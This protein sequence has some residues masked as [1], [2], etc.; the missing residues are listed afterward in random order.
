[1]TTYT[2][3]TKCGHR[4]IIN[5][6]G[7]EEPFFLVL[8]CESETVL[9]EGETKVRKPWALSNLGIPQAITLSEALRLTAHWLSFYEDEELRQKAADSVREAYAQH[10]RVAG[11]VRPLN[12]SGLSN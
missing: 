8:G 10:E 12:P 4:L 3:W 5:V 11:P 2:E 6:G 7:D 1:M 9:P